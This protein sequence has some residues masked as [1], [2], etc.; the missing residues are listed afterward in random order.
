MYKA[1]D[2]FS[3]RCR[4][5]PA[6]GASVP[7]FLFTPP[8]HMTI[9]GAVILLHECVGVQQYVLTTAHALAGAG[10]VVAVPNLFRESVP[11]MSPTD[12]RYTNEETMNAESTE[13]M[14]KMQHLNWPAAVDDVLA[15]SQYLHEAY[16]PRGVVTWG[17]SMGGA[18]SLLVASKGAPQISASIA[19]YGYPDSKTAAGAGNLFDARAVKV[20][21]LF[22]SGSMDPFEG[23]SAPGMTRTVKE[24]LSNTAVTSIVQ[25]RCGHSFMNDAPWWRLDGGQHANET[26]RRH[27]FA[28]AVDF[29]AAHFGVKPGSWELPPVSVACKSLVVHSPVLASSDF[30]SFAGGSSVTGAAGYCFIGLIV[31]SALSWCILLSKKWSSKHSAPVLDVYSHFSS[32]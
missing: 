2:Q 16:E 4:Y 30:S 9:A 24:E 25:E 7:A 5:P 29:L 12:C 15:T 1:A 10:F 11:A 19:F 26:C 27:G 22:E 17:F 14:W 3:E 20:P 13:C 8:K 23:F 31:G 32:S 21:V 6:V 18:L 28:S